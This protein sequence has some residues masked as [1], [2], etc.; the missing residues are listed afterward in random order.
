[1]PCCSWKPADLRQRER[2]YAPFAPHKLSWTGEI[3]LNACIYFSG[4]S[5]DMADTS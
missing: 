3:I 1:M 5:G 2:R 4:E